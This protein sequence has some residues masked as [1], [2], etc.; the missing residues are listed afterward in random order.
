MPPAPWRLLLAS[1]ISPPLA[2]GAGAD[3]PSRQAPFDEPVAA[4]SRQQCRDPTG[5]LPNEPRWERRRA[6]SSRSR[7]AERTRRRSC[8][9]NTGRVTV[10]EPTHRTQHLAVERTEPV[11]TYLSGRAFGRVRFTLRGARRCPRS[12]TRSSCSASTRRWTRS[13]RTSRR[14]CC[15]PDTGVLVLA[16]DAPALIAYWTAKRSAAGT[17]W[18]D[19]AAAASCKCCIHPGRARWLPRRDT[20]R[21]RFDRNGARPCGHSVDIAESQRGQASPARAVPHAAW[22]HA[23]W[24]PNRSRDT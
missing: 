18:F 2:S 15:S 14:S 10:P 20:T 19:P 16:V 6:R 5:I 17:P 9:R 23:R 1:D 12:R 8:A 13:L 11:A 3:N 7:A 22:Y 4:R 21:F 24:R